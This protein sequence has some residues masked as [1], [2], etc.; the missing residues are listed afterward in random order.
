MYQW[1]L[2]KPQV[3]LFTILAFSTS[4]LI[5]TFQDMLKKFA[6]I[7]DPDQTASEEQCD[8]GR[9]HLPSYFVSKYFM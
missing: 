9:H 2:Q 4:L 5:W 3:F 6:H 1:F 7:A 8:L